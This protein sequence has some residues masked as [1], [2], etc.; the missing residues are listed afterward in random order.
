MDLWGVLRVRIQR[1]RDTLDRVALGIGEPDG[2]FPI[3]EFIHHF[4]HQH[5][6]LYVRVL[7]ALGYKRTL[8]LLAIGGGKV[9]PWAIGVERLESVTV[10]AGSLECF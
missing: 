2:P 10:P 5:V 9:V 1:H 6:F 4:E 7:L 3:E 8:Q